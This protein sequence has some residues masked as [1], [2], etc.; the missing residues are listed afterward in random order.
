MKISRI[1]SNKNDI[2]EPIKFHDGLNVIIG[3]IRK[4]ENL[5][6]DTHN[7]GKSKLCELIDFC[8]LKKRSKNFFLFKNTEIFNGFIFYLEVK[9]NSGEYIT[10]RRSVVSNTKISIIK[11]KRPYQDFSQLPLSDWDY[12]NIS[13]EKSKEL[14]DAILNLTSISHWDY[15]TALGYS[16]RGQNDYDDVF[17]LSD[18][19]GKH[20]YWK[21]YI[22]HMLGFNS[23]NLIKNYKLSDDIDRENGKLEDLLNDAGSIIGD[24][25]E[26]IAGLLKIKNKELQV[27]DEQMK[28]FNF[29]EYDIKVIED[30]AS[31]I[32]MEISELNKVRYYLNIS[33]S[34]L[35]KTQSHQEIKFNLQDMKDLFND[36]KIYFGDSVTRTYNELIEFNKQITEERISFAQEQ[37]HENE[38]EL[39]SVNQRLKELNIERSDKLSFI[40]NTSYLDKYKKLNEE[41]IS[42][43]VEI[44]TL[45]NKLETSEKIKKI[46]E[47]ISDKEDEK[48]DLIKEIKI[49]RDDVVRSLDGIYSKIKDRFTDFVKVVLDKDGLLTTEMNKEGNLQYWAGMVN[50][51]GQKTSESDGHSYQKILCIGYDI[52][53]LCAY[54]DKKFLRFIYHDGGLETLDNRK[55]IQFLNYVATTSQDLNFQYILTLIDS[56]LPP[57]YEFPPQTIVKVLHDDG[58]DGLLF[59]M[60]PW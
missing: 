25:E 54:L 27:L 5:E 55:K 2:F 20:L 6:T 33:I 16:L 42:L 18:F 21:P 8:L 53:V 19:I 35:R 51:Q 29:D 39:F 37:I 1:Y 59:K 10:I 36:A 46:R 52:A 60:D 13:F 15:R 23:N 38:N 7:L 9:T 49:D 34:K 40:K 57:G 24:G 31:K 47:L 26:L 50:S 41:I 48:K 44:N 14:L 4:P 56:D 45:E 12:I 32:D 3:E 30:L 58:N 22:G 43:N 11:H 28:S 17:R